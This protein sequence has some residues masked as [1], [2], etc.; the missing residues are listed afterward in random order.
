MTI[1]Q[2]LTNSHRVNDASR[3]VF[4]TN[5]CKLLPSLYIP[6]LRKR[7]ANDL[8]QTTIV[9]LTVEDTGIGIP[10]KDQDGLFKLFGK[11]SSNHNRNKTGCGLG[12][13]ICRKILQKLGGDIRLTSEEG[14]GT[15]V[16][17]IFQCKY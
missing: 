5:P 9:C 16:Q 6:T 2:E 15:T 13:T 17:C 11:L 1:N 12:L 3:Y 8:S 7:I 10:L 4:K 14:K